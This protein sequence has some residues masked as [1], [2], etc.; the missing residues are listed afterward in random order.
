LT[1]ITYKDKKVHNVK[2]EVAKISNEFFPKDNPQKD[3]QIYL[4]IRQ[5]VK[6]NQN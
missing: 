3:E 2:K 1:S 5:Q 6:Q 4:Q